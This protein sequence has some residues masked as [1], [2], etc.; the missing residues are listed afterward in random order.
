MRVPSLSA[1]NRSTPAAGRGVPQGQPRHAPIDHVIVSPP[2]QSAPCSAPNLSSS[3]LVLKSERG[4]DL[5][6]TLPLLSR[7][8]T[9]SG[10]TMTLRSGC[11]RNLSINSN[12]GDIPARRH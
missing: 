9:S 6:L 2:N 4:E 3:L 1:S 5:E 12:S 8:I 11:K 7:Q 10:P